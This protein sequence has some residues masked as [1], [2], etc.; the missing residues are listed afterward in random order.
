M[1]RST[2]TW[3]RSR[4][5]DSIMGRVLQDF[6]EDQFTIGEHAVDRN[7]NAVPIWDAR[8]V[9]FDLHGAVCKEFLGNNN[10]QILIHKRLKRLIKAMFP[11][12]YKSAQQ[13]S[14]S[15]DPKLY[16]LSDKMSFNQVKKVISMS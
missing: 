13:D 14:G 5:V 7:G 3:S 10:A 2:R 6:T 1:E 11:D 4:G 15:T 8:A 9:K 16:Q 12:V